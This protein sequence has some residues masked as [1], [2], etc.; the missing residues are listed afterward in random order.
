[1]GA[2]KSASLELNIPYENC[3]QRWQ[4]ILHPILKR[5]DLGIPYNHDWVDE[6]FQYI[7]EN[8]IERL[9]E[10]D[11][12]HILKNISP[13]E[14][15]TSV[16]TILSNV[17]NNFLLTHNERASLHELCKRRLEDN[18]KLGFKSRVKFNHKAKHANKIIKGYKKIVQRDNNEM[19]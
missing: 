2:I 8:K 15:K 5:H 11:F 7:V 12:K 14:T 18:S 19:I 3:Y 9:D 10:V 1:M 6:M 16:R 4:N 17:L 13:G